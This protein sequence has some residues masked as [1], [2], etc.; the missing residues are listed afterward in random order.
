V[1]V[2]G[3]PQNQGPEITRHFLTVLST[4]EPKPFTQ[5]SGR[6]ELA[7]SIASRS[8]PLTARVLVNR[9]WRWHFG[10]GLVRTPS[11]FGTRGDLPTHPELLDW[12]ATRFMDSGWS[13]KK[14]HKTIMLTSAYTESSDVNPKS[15]AVDPEN[16]LVWHMNRRRLDLEATRDSLLY[17]AGR[18]DPKIGGPSVEITTAPFSTRRTVY[19][20]IDRQNLQ[21]LYR[22]FDFASPDQTSPQRFTTTIPQQALFMMN[23]PFVIEQARAVVTR[24]EIAAA[25]D[26]TGKIRAL[27][28]VVFG[29][30]PSP[31][32]I[33]LGL[34]FVQS[35]GGDGLRNVSLEAKPQASSLSAWDRYAQALLMSNEFSFVD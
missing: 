6:L 27:Y 19:G 7:E 20:Y 9:I 3:N 4:G 15:F 34:R 5:G 17:V 25:E 10:Q 29:R 22:T 21:G 8:N 14:L 26:D 23:S 2:R 16:R 30:D 11:D 33:S 1:L 24:K 35:A 12:L 32:E 31:S 28:R 13:I 18:L